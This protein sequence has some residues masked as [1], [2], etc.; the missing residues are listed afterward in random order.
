M[1]RLTVIV[2]KIIPFY[3]WLPSPQFQNNSS[4]AP[5]C[6][7][8]AADGFSPLGNYFE[9]I[10]ELI[11]RKNDIEYKVDDIGCLVAKGKTQ[12]I[13]FLEGVPG[14]DI[15][16]A[17]ENGTNL[18]EFETQTSSTV[19]ANMGLYYFGARFYDADV[20]R[21]V[22][23]DPAE[24]YSN[25]YLYSGNNPINRIDPDGLWDGFI[26][27]EGEA[28]CVIGIDGAAGIVLDTDEAGE[29][30][31]FVSGSWLDK[32]TGYGAG[33]AGG[34]GIA[35]YEIEGKALNNDV[36]AGPISLT[37][38]FD[39]N[40]LAGISVTAGKGIAFVVSETET[41]SFTW[42]DFT[43]AYFKLNDRVLDWLMQKVTYKW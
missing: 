37:L 3:P 34:A 24:Q 2:V 40:G 11:I 28:A 7:L 10:D 14:D 26:Y 39:D 31:V 27:V 15:R 33:I 23:T 30:G 29:S 35:F 5:V 19:L 32:T 22:S 9:L 43:D 16:N 17:A 6:D 8:S 41:K 4:S 25:L 36:N 12:Q 20:G 42:N 13:S 18:F 21:W 1:K 38:T